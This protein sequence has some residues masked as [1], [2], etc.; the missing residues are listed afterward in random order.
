MSKRRSKR[1]YNPEYPALAKRE[2]VKPSA[3]RLMPIT[4]TM[5]VL[6]L[7]VKVNSLYHSS[8]E[9]LRFNAAYAEDAPEEAAEAKDDD[10]EVDED[11]MAEDEDAEEAEEAEAKDE[12]AEEAVEAMKDAEPGEEGE[13]KE[14]EMASLEEEPKVE[15]EPQRQF[16]QIELDIL[17]SL[18]KRRE[19]LEERGRELDLKE[20]LLEA[21]ELRINDKLNEM[22]M[23][24]ADVE[25]LLVQYNEHE[26]AKIKS[27]VKIYE[28]MKPKQASEIFNELDMPIL[29]E[30][31]DMMSE[32]KVAPV[33]AGMDP[34][35]ARELTEE[36][37][38]FRKLKA[39]PRTLGAN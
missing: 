16:S 27:L 6:L 37:A 15:E 32:R 1:Q 10:A 21:T 20:K 38:E 8:Q 18:S 11:E 3:F 36:L 30:V 7:G 29:L 5:A 33:L 19:E 24:K 23:L 17:Q 9:L 28:S 26:D 12:D 2:K 13:A 39:I 31:V 35:R 34:E 25:Q 14:I 22:K 4:I